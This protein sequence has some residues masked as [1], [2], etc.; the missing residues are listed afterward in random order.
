M[1]M[2]RPVFSLVRRAWVVL[3]SA[4]MLTLVPACARKPQLEEPEQP[5]LVDG[6]RVRSTDPKWVDAR[7]NTVQV[8]DKGILQDVRIEY[9]GAQFVRDGRLMAYAVL[10][11][12]SKEPL[13][14]EARAHFFA[15]DQSPLEEADAWVKVPVGPMAMTPFRILS[16]A[17]RTPAYY[18][19]E[20]RRAVVE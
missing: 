8:L 6:L 18:M 2:K 20:L 14:L 19:I 10:R 11:S 5:S 3:L 4:G 16:E 7:L 1:P 17:K 13:L 9:T 12:R 15:R